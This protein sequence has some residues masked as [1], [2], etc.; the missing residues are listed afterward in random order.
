[1]RRPIKKRRKQR[2]TGHLPMSDVGERKDRLGSMVDTWPRVNPPRHVRSPRPNSTLTVCPIIP[3]FSAVDETTKQGPMA[4]GIGPAYRHVACCACG[5][6]LRPAS[7]GNT[8]WQGH[9]CPRQGQCSATAHAIAT[10]VAEV[11]VAVADRDRS[12]VVAGW[13]VDLEL[14]KL[15]LAVVQ[16]GLWVD[17]HP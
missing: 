13:G 2:R 5:P 3:V 14:G 7:P 10:V 1:M 12:A 9:R 11:A 4:Y 17:G 8:P 16:R 15:A 6:C